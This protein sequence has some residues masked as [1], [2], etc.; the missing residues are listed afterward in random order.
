LWSRE[1]MVGAVR[2]GFRDGYRKRQKLLRWF[3]GSDVEGGGK[4]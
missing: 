2:A 1:P 3:G 4:S